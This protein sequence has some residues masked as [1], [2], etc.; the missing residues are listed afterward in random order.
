MPSNGRRRTKDC[1][2]L[3]GRPLGT[4]DSQD[5]DRIQSVYPKKGRKYAARLVKDTYSGVAGEIGKHG[6]L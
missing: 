2:H 4:E 6:G 5:A 3:E 1:V